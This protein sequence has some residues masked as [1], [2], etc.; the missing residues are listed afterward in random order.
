MPISGLSI[1]WLSEGDTLV[2]P[3]KNSVAFC[4]EG[5]DGKFELNYEESVAHDSAIRLVKCL[6]DDLLLTVDV[7]NKA[8][9]WKFGED[10]PTI[11]CSFTTD[12][13]VAQIE[14]SPTDSALALR[15]ESGK[16]ML[17]K[18]EFE[19]AKK[20]EV[21]PPEEVDDI[22]LEGFDAAD[23]EIP[24]ELATP[25]EDVEVA[26]EAEEQL[27]KGA[28]SPEKK[29][30]EAKASETHS[31]IPKFGDAAKEMQVPEEPE[32]VDDSVVVEE[33]PAKEIEAEPQQHSEPKKQESVKQSPQKSVGKASSKQ[34]NEEPAQI[35]EEAPASQ[36]NEEDVDMD[37]EV[38]RPKAVSFE[39]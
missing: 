1:E 26:K 11:V 5:D 13:P 32:K 12:E 20:F 23:F 22:D 35:E 18:G 39:P 31:Q 19:T 2:L 10:L 28:K 25:P 6:K 9:I 29:D 24:E 33:E 7:D 15:G 14:W 3:G 38:Q 36:P 37:P 34:L 17:V 8:K 16:I 21:L 30:I 27:E 4:F